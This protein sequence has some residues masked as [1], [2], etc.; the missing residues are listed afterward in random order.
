[1]TPESS[2]LLAE[3]LKCV[4][5][6]DNFCP[7]KIGRRIG[8]TKPQAYSAA[9]ILSNEGVLSLGFDFAANFT[10]EY[11]KARSTAKSPAG[12]SAPSSRRRASARSI[13]RN[14]IG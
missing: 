3:V 8:L 10:P 1:M 14:K 7:A 12:N 9:R 11:R 4:P 13:A 6:T 2:L 5:L